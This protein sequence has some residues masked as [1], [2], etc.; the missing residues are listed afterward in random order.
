MGVLN[1]KG[2]KQFQNFLQSCIDET[3]YVCPMHK[4]VAAK[5]CD[6][7]CIKLLR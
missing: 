2:K 5:S 4:L 1:Q 3:F 7:R 6:I